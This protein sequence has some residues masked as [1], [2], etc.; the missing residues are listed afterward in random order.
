MID[1]EKN[2][3]HSQQHNLSRPSFFNLSAKNDK[4]ALTDLLKSGH[5][6]AVDTYESQLRDYFE[7]KNPT[8]VFSPELKSKFSAYLED[9][10]KEST[11]EEQGIWVYLP[12]R[13]T[14]TH[15][16]IENEFQE[17]RTA[18][19]KN[20]I[21]AE[22]QAK[23]YHSTIGIAGL[24]VGNSVALAIVLQGGGRHLKLADFDS[25]EL[26]NT[27]RI[28]ASI[29]GLGLKK[30][31]LTAQQIYELNPYAE[32]ELFPDGLTEK[33][34]DNFFEGLDIVIDE[35]DNLAMKWKIREFAQKFKLPVLMGADNGDGVVID[36]E[37]Y[38]L[39]SD[40]EFFNGR[41]PGVSYEKLKNLGKIET[42]QLI[43]QLVG[44]ENVG[45][46]ML[47]SLSE[48]GK[49]LVSWPQLG[50]AATLNGSAISCYARKILNNQAVNFKRIIFS[51]K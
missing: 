12:W 36:I 43:T 17:V 19:N 51:F 48:I 41:L 46:R 50:G 39:T 34:M 45:Q 23:F 20:L 3:T 2:A 6:R 28:R 25:L 15:I 42:G 32:L 11:I 18:R 27:N 26:T 16:L 10:K 44:P 5:V 13:N 4:Q 37:R 24:S 9:L 29:D 1:S 47:G 38:D 30:V 31:E 8:L 22:E 21:T 7:I 14:V 33:N 35:I 49:T 40:L